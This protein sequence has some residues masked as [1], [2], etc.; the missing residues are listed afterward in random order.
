[1]KLI[2]PQFWQT[3]TWVSRIL[4][5]LAWLYEIGTML[6]WF[7]IHPQRV[8]IPVVCVGNFTMGGSGKTPVVL[9]LVEQLVHMNIHQ[10]HE[11]A[12]L[13]RGY[14]GRCRGPLR[15]DPLTHTATDVGDEP[16]L[17]AQAAPTWIAHN[18]YDGARAAQNDGAKIIIMDDG[19]QN[20]QLQ[21]DCRLVVVDGAYGF[22]NGLVFPA[23]PLRENLRHGLNTIHAFLVIGI[24][25]EKH[26]IQNQDGSKNFQFNFQSVTTVDTDR[27]QPVIAFAG[28][29]HP[30]KF[31][32]ALLKAKVNV[33]SFK[34]FPDHHKYTNNDLDKL[35]QYAQSSQ[36]QLLTTV[37]DYMRLPDDFKSHVTVCHQKLIL[38]NNNDLIQFII[39]CLEDDEENS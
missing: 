29:G 34:S 32:H 1:M 20:R 35:L 14:G 23:G 39:E 15:V 2:A 6:H 37:K 7:F 18:R 21:H 4:K 24:G 8:N 13:S 31:H 26:T 28:I 16:L 12:I 33:I 19:L 5:P 3:Q 17:L 38:D 27:E 9:Y 30:Q 10:R 25:K 22:G 36:A 11:I